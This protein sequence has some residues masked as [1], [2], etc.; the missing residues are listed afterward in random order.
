[1]VTLKK[2]APP[3]QKSVPPAPAKAPVVAQCCAKISRTVAGCH[4]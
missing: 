3:Q 1:M 4:D 2:K